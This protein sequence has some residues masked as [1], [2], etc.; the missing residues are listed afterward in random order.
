MEQKEKQVIAELI[1]WDGV[2]E[3]IRI[4]REWIDDIVTA[5]QAQCTI[6]NN[7]LGVSIKGG[8]YCHVD[9]YEVDDDT[10]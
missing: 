9:I 5:V 10:D 7:M 3:T 8:N 2:M 4:K 6:V 1:R